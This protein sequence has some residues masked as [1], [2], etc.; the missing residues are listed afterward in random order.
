MDWSITQQRIVIINNDTFLKNKLFN[1]LSASRMILMSKFSL[2]LV[3]INLIYIT[4]LNAKPLAIEPG[5][6]FTL[7][8]NAGYTIGKN[9]LSTSG[10]NDEI[11]SINAEI[12]TTNSFIGFP[13]GRIEYTTE[14]LKNQFFLG[15]IREQISVSQFQYELGM[16]H[17]FDNESQL[18]VAYFPHLP[19]FN[20]TWKDPYL[21]GES[22]Q[23][24][25]EN[26]QGARIEL[27]RVAGSPVTLKYAFAVSDIEDD[28]S[29]KNTLINNVS[30]TE[31][32]LNSLQ[33]N[34][35][36]HRVAVETLIPLSQK[37]LLKPALQYTKR[38]ADGD[39][40]SYDDYNVQ[41]GFL[42]FNGAHSLI[43]TVNMGTTVY[44]QKNPI[45]DQKQNSLNAGIFTI[46]AYKKPFNW[47]QS[48]FTMMTGYN[49][50]NSDI[51]FHDESGFIV[52]TGFAFDF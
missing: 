43:T 6:K 23:K 34:S 24:T 47:Q 44:K 50:K 16:T 9:N 36:Y 31:K 11:S 32:E 8:L 20:E 40:N 26:V 15:N 21:V 10:D 28:Q 3:I 12:A 48:T 37:I 30:L 49:Q 7:S 46:Y 2:P 42:M 27:T 14:D 13:L 33:R 17:Q 35:Q 52:S 41:L 19:L 4:G 39:A 1:V 38:M 45:F 18:T 22:R 51:N 29:G 25:D 5:W